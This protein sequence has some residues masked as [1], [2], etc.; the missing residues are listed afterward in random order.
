MSESLAVDLTGLD[1][2][3]ATRSPVEAGDTFVGKDIL[4]LVS[5]SMYVEPLT[6]YREY[7]QNAVDSIDMA[8]DQ[9]LLGTKEDGEVYISLSQ[10]TRTIL[11][12]DNGAGVSNKDFMSVMLSFGG[13]SKRGTE[14]RGFRGV[15]RFSGLGYCQKL[16]FRSKATG[17]RKAMES[18]WDGRRLKRLLAS[19]SDALGISDLVHEVVEFYEYETGGSEDSFF[20]VELQG[21]VR[22][23]SDKLLSEERVGSYLSQCAPVPYSDDF[24]HRSELEPILEAYGICPGYT[25][26]LEGDFLPRKKIFRPYRRNFSLTDTLFDELSEPKV[27]EL[28]GLDGEVSAVGWL[29][30]QSYKG[31]IPARHNIRGVRV[32]AGNIQ[33]GGESLL[34][35]AFPE[36]RFNS[37]AVGEVHIVDRRIRPNGRRDNFDIN[38]HWVEL[39]NQFAAHAKEVARL[40]RKNSAERNTVKQFET[41][42]EKA[43]VDYDALESGVFSKSQTKSLKES[44]NG[45]LVRA[46]RMLG[47]SRLRDETAKKLWNSLDKAK[48]SMGLLETDDGLTSDIFDAI[49]KH[50]APAV[51][52][53]FDLLYEC[54]PNKVVATTILEKICDA[55]R[56]RYGDG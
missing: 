14:A 48:K 26:E 17:D 50:K 11:I 56:A 7:V 20:E 46:E 4:E 32:R 18:I 12:R 29:F 16:I 23:G 25:I 19:Q 45:S 22:L 47:S 54:A 3:E 41:L 40:C 37:W 31:L 27:F 52:E 38:P 33:V 43:S 13:S 15:G 44:V 6:L 9:G 1:R 5:V 35:E 49:P 8:V 10:S 2:Q 55:Y 39:N 24:P 28:S 36:P 21:V 30:G 42:L 51:R 34:C 53:V